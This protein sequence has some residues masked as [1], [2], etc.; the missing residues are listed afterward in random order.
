MLLLKLA[1]D[2]PE[3]RI[4]DKVLLSERQYYLQDIIKKVTDKQVFITEVTEEFEV[5]C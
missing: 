1:L 2:L 4:F 3:L 5:S